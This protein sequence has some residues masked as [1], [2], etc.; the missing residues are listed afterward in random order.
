[1]TSNLPPLQSNLIKLCGPCSFHLPFC[2]LIWCIAAYFQV[3]LHLFFFIFCSLFDPIILSIYPTSF[4]SLSVSQQK[5][6]IWTQV[7]CACKDEIL[8]ASKAHD[9]PKK[10]TSLLWSTPNICVVPLMLF[11]E[12]FEKNIILSLSLVIILDQFVWLVLEIC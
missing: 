10:G 8:I 9:Q 2:L 1:M 4:A 12:I 7:E 3:Q 5:T 11:L 6:R